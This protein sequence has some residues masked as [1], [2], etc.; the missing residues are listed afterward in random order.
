[1]AG[2]GTNAALTDCR[3]GLDH[4]DFKGEPIITPPK[5]LNYIARLHTTG[6]HSASLRQARSCTVAKGMLSDVQVQADPLA[7]SR[8]DRY[9]PTS[10]D[11][12]EP[13]AS[14]QTKTGYGVT[15]VT[16]PIGGGYGAHGPRQHSIPSIRPVEKRSR[17]FGA[18]LLC[19]FAPLCSGPTCDANSAGPVLLT[20]GPLIEAPARYP[21]CDVR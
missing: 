9:H 6:C 1:M 11:G 18:Q 17:I 3:R 19:S 15:L 8:Y 7:C 10:R 2:K 13:A 5:Q 4:I 16:S 12:A 14:Q 20:L 21:G